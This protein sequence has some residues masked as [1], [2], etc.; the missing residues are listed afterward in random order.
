MAKYCPVIGGRV[1]YL[2]CQECDDKVCE[3]ENDS[4]STMKQVGQITAEHG[5]PEMPWAENGIV[6]LRNSDT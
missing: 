4:V 5:I 3:K 6:A 1:V 2:T